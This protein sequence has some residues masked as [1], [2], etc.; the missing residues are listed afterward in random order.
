MLILGVAAARTWVTPFETPFIPRLR[1]GCGYGV[2]V[3]RTWGR[4]AA[5]GTWGRG[6]GG[7]EVSD[8]NKHI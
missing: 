8:V 5:A 6:A 4:E 1:L 3:A 2:A 7:F